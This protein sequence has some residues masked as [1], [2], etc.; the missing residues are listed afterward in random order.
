MYRLLQ[1]YEV[2]EKDDEIYIEKKWYKLNM[3]DDFPADLPIRR[4][5][6]PGCPYTT[7]KDCNDE[8]VND[9]QLKQILEKNHEL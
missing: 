8:W 5:F 6:I 3:T 9:L 7:E 2:V 1:K 4:K